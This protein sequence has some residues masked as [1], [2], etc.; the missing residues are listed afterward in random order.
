M[1]M[2]F[3]IKGDGNDHLR[4]KDGIIKLMKNGTGCVITQEAE[5]EIKTLHG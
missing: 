1:A 5:K 2:V 4:L 3:E